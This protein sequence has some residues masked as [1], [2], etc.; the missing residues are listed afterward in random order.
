VLERRFLTN[1][2]PY[3]RNGAR[4]KHGTLT[5]TRMRCI[6]WRYFWWSWVTLNHHNNPNHSISVTSR[7]CTKTAEQMKLV[8]ATWASISLTYTVLEG[9]RVSLQIRVLLSRTY[10]KTL[11]LDNF[12]TARYLSQM[13]STLVDGQCCKLVTVVDHQF[14]YHTDHRHL[15]TTRWAWGTASRGSVRGSEHLIIFHC[16]SKST[17]CYRWSLCVSLF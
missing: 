2:S 11:D 13:L 7:H 9:I 6:K 4:Q 12:A 8:F 14:I 3:R 16:Q 1:I 15:C 10:T 17:Y 5:G